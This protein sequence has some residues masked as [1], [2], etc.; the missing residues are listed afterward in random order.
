MAA[1]AIMR[2]KKLASMGSV[3]SSLKHCFRERETLN[4]DPERT[5][6]N[7]HA[8]GAARSTDEAMGKLRAMLPEKRRKDAVLVVEYMLTASPEWWA[9]ATPDEQ[10]KFFQRAHGWLAKKYGQDK[11]IVATVHRDETSPHL[12]AFVVPLTQDGR[13]SAKEFIGNRAQMQADQTSF[14]AAVRDLGLERGIPGSKAKHQSIRAYYAAIATG[15]KVVPQLTAEELKPQ[16]VPG[17]TVME[18]LLGAQETQEGVVQR[19]NRKL[20]THVT[21]LAQN[22]ALARSERSR[23]KEMQETAELLKGYARTFQGLS[24]EQINEV[25]QLAQEHR[26]K[27]Q[28]AERQ[29]Q[30]DRMIDR[31]M[32]R[33]KARIAAQNKEMGRGPGSDLSCPRKESGG[34][35]LER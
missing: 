10:Q 32:K 23:A 31:E 16:R 21:P 29:K 14:A 13:L 9:K 30:L 11:I 28:Q 12:S 25:L 8:K 27:N 2:C 4:A 5:P 20:K 18:K 35:G 19:I 24:K 26:Q 33:E 7:M 3:A 1:Y 6:S 17:E 22:A 15:E 34:G